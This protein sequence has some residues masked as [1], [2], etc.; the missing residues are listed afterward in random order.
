MGSPREEEGGGEGEDSDRTK[1]HGKVASKGTGR[2]QET[3]RHSLTA[4]TGGGLFLMSKIIIINFFRVEFLMKKCA[5][6]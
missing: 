3:E 5:C 4:C 1:G 6:M 2:C